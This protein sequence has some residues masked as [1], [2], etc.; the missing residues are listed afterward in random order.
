MARATRIAVALLLSAVAA[1]AEAGPPLITNDPDTP[2]PGVWEINL[3]A[4]GISGAGVLGLDAPDLDLNRGVGERVQLSMHAA[5]AHERDGNGWRS[6]LGDVEFGVRYRFMDAE[7]SGMSLAIQ[8]LYTRSW[9]A[10]ARR[11][12]LASEHPE[13][14]VPVQLARP[15][16]AFN[17][18]L[19]VSRHFITS[20]PDAWQAGVF[21]GHDCW[22]GEC[23]AEINSTRVDHAGARTTFNLG[24]RHPIADGVDFLGSVGRQYG[25]REAA[26]TVFYVGVQII[27]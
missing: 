3:A 24:N 7:T 18:G 20:E 6:G 27:R 13:W 14:V 17:A 10:A 26:A 12:G 16:G 9:S 1:Q 11:R 2:G 21:A 23:L 22:G 4:T 5:W 19:E 15:F 25:G 8:P